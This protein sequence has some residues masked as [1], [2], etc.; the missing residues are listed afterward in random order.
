MISSPA[1]TAYSGTSLPRKL[2]LVTTKGGI[3]EVAVIGEPEG[4]RDLLGS[5]PENVILHSHLRLTSKLALCFVRSKAELAAIL[6]LLK[7][8]LP[9]KCHVW[10][11]HLKAHRKPEFNQNELRHLALDAGLVD[12]KVCSVDGDWSGLKFA[13]RGQSKSLGHRMK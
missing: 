6:D 4:F 8:Q 12:Y 7:G 1:D 2:G 13:W 5:L 10:L 3:G 11:I 9:L